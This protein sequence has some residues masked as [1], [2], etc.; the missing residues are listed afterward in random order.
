MRLINRWFD[1]VTFVGAV[2]MGACA[3]SCIVDY[4]RGGDGTTLGAAG[5]FV[6]LSLWLFYMSLQLGSR[7]RRAREKVKRPTPDERQVPASPDQPSG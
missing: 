3:A 6:L 7:Q 1:L 4:T 5:V 2:F